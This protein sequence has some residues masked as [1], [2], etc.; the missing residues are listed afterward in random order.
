MDDNLKLLAF[1]IDGSGS[2]SGLEDDTIGGF[3]SLIEKQKEELNKSIITTVIF[4]NEYRMIHENLNI[5]KIKPLTKEDYFVRGATALY[6]A[7]GITIDKIGLYLN[8]VS[9]ANKPYKVVITIITDGLENASKEFTESKIKEM[10]KH[11]T[12][13]YNWEFIYI[14]ANVDSF[15]N[16]SSLNIN[17]Y[18]NYTAS[19]VGTQSVYNTINRALSKSEAITNEDLKGII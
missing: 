7:I 3:N 6:D 12:E 5:D 15:K 9:E 18:A 2:M 10:I 17:T 13:K 1:I 8:S 19:T 11:Q 14:G 4:D 16:S